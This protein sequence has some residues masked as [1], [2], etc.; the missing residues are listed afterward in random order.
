MNKQEQL[1]YITNLRVQEMGLPCIRCVTAY[2]KDNTA[3]LTFY[4]DRTPLEEDIENA[5]DICGEIIASFPDGLLEENYTKW[6]DPNPLPEKFLAY[7]R[8]G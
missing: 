3:C 2:W 6:G 8:K 4:F 5:S 7:A 1:L